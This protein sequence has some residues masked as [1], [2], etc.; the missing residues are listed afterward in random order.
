[1]KE[2]IVVGLL[3]NMAILLSFSMLYENA[4]LRQKGK[5]NIQLHIVIG[6]ALSVISVLLMLNSWQLLPGV[7]FDMRSVLLSVAALFFGT[8]PTVIMIVISSLYR[9]SMGG[10]GQWMGIAII[11]SSGVIGLLWRNLRPQWKTESNT[12]RELIAL[13][14]VVHL[15][16]VLNIIFLP[17]EQMFTIFKQVILP[18]LLI[19]IPATLILGMLLLRHYRNWQNRTAHQKLQVVEQQMRKILD[20]GN[21]VSLI[22]NTDGSVRY[23]NEYLSDITGYSKKEIEGKNWFRCFIADA[24]KDGLCDMFVASV[25][26]KTIPRTHQTQILSNCN[27]V[28]H[29]VCHNIILF[30]EKGEVDGVASIGVNI[31]EQKRYEQELKESANKIENHNSE[32]NKLNEELIVAKE[33]AEESDRLK[34]A[35]LANMSH[36]IR[37]PMNGI[38]G[39]TGLLKEPDLSEEQM[40][41]Y[42]GIIEKSGERM[43]NIINDIIDIS[44]IEAG[45][46][47]VSLENANIND[48]LVYIHSFFEEE[49]KQKGIKLSFELN[50]DSNASVIETDK[51]KVYA[52]LTN[53]VKNAIK[54]SEAETIHMGYKRVNGNLQFFVKDTGIGISPAR[55]KAIFERFIQADIEN[56]NAIQ[57]AGLGLAISKAYVD[58]LGGDMWVESEPG[59]GAMFVFTLP[60][61]PVIVGV[62]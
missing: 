4:W 14:V 9:Y 19:Y 5:H 24:E 33:R 18:I 13:G 42:I 2:S 45:L 17:A 36:E 40:S 28:L 11:I 58:M 41:M 34:S 16:M 53:L 3:Q 57:G 47:K 55:Q 35:F 20:S 44:K 46:M 26:N 37:T 38:L 12:K 54:Y 25:R 22:L 62:N 43:L 39:F 27:E 48:Q 59:D 15:F 56:Q 23:C 50:L 51:E 29:L 32:L 21:I 7:V 60:Y 61:K 6:L 52:I 30:G 10:E 49:V 31:T 8:V 1:M